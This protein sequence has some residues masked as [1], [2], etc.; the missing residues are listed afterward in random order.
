MASI[1]Y[2]WCPGVQ[3]LDAKGKLNTPIRQQLLGLDYAD[4]RANWFDPVYCANT[5]RPDLR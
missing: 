5:P 2:L 1:V 4:G 3:V